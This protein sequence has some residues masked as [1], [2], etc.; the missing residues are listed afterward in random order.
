MNLVGEN[1]TIIPVEL[2]LL[3]TMR[4]VCV[5]LSVAIAAFLGMYVYSRIKFN[6]TEEHQEFL[7]YKKE[8]K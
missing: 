1:T 5:G 8:H 4:T 6:K 7:K 2:A 3:K